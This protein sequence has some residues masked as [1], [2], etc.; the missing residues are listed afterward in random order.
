MADTEDITPV[1]DPKRA[2]SKSPADPAAPAAGGLGSATYE[3]I[4]Q[5]LQAQGQALRECMS[6]LDA[7]RQEVFGSI[8]YELLQADRI[9]TA[10][11]CIPRD[12]VQLGDGRFLFGFNIQFGLKQQV[13]LAD[14]FAVYSRENE[15]GGFKEAGLEVLQDDRFLADFKR[16]YNVYEKTAFRKLSVIEGQLYMV[17]ATGSGVNDIA[18]FKWAFD[19]GALRYIDGRAEAEYRRVGFPAP[20]EFRWRL[21]DRESYRYGDHPHISIEDRVFVECT[22]GDLTIKVEDNTATGQGIYAEPVDDQYQKVDDADV[23]YAIL[24]HLILLKIRPYKEARARFFIYN[25]KLESVSRVDSL[26]QSCVLLPED[27]GL[28]FPDGYYLAT[29]ELKRFESKE[30]DMLIERVVRAPNGEDVLYVFYNRLT[31]DYVLMPYRLIGQKVEE[32]FSCNGFTLFPNGHFALFRAEQ[33]P[34]KHHMIQLW[35]TPFHQPG[36]EPAG[37]REA[38]LYQVG[39]KA[40]VRC[41]SEC[42]EVLTLLRKESPYAELYTDLVKRCGTILDAYSW[43]AGDEGFGMDA[44]LRQVREAADKAVDEF[45]KVR[46]LRQEAVRRVSASRERCEE[47]FQEVRRASFSRLNDYVGNL[48]ALRQL[49]GELITLKEVRYVEVA[50]VDEIEKQVAAETAAL[51]TACVRFLLKPEALEPY[52]K[53]ATEQLERVE[54]IAKV[55]EGRDI[56]KAVARAGS[57]L[58]MLIEIVNGLKIEDA[59]ETTRIIDGITAVYST[60]NQVKGAL[61]KQLKKLTASEKAAQFA[62]QL[63]L[64]GQSAASYLDLC[65]TPAKCEDYL[66]RISVQ[67]EELEGT[68]ADFEDYVVQLSE[69]RTELYEAFEQRKVA[70]IEQRN[71]RAGALMTAAERILKVIQN[72]LAGFK[73]LEE[74]NTYM[75]SDLMI[76]KVRETIDQLMALEDSVKADDLQGR[77]KSAQQEA[78]RQ[79]KDRQELF[80]EGQA[81]IKLGQ[82]RFNINTQPLDLTVVNRDRAQFIHLTSTK[83][84]DRITDE[85]FL[86]TRDVWDQEVVSENAEVYRGEYLAHR[87]LQ[88][89]EHPTG[90]NGDSGLGSPAPTP[91][92]ALA[93]TDAE[94]LAVVRQFISGRY[95]EGY[96]KGIHDHDGAQIFKALLSAHLSLQLA[97][98]E[99]VARACALVFWH[100]FCPADTVALWT[101]KLSGF[102][103]RNRLFPGDPGQADYTAALES[104]L[105]TFTRDTGLYSGTVV[106]AAGEYLF[107][108]LIGGDTVAISRDAQELL[109]AFETHL[110]TQGSEGLFADARKALA[111]HPASE[112]ELVRD[113]VRGF[114]LGR[115]DQEPYAEE[116]VALLFCGEDLNRS[117]VEAGTRQELDAMKGSHARIEGSRYRF[118]Y[119]GFRRRLRGFELEVVPRFLQSH[120]LKQALLDR[121]R[122]ALRLDEFRPRVL[123]SFVRNQLLD[124][125]YLPLI[126][127]NLAK[128]VG[129]AGDQRRTDLM[130]LLLLISPPGYGKTTLMEY[131]ASRLGIVFIKINGPALGHSVSSLDPEEAPN[132]AAREEVR[133][134]NLALEMGDNA[135][136]Y[137]DDIQHCNP[138]FL[139]KFISLCDAQRK[140][141]GVWRGQ[142]RTYDL[143]GRKVVVVM[144]GNPYTESGQK[145]KIPDML[146]N[147]ADTYNLGDIIGGSAD[148]FKMSYLENA[149]TSNPVLAP[150][151]N[152]SQKDI[153]AFIHMA[154]SG[155]G[156]GDGFEGS[157]AS[158]EIEEILA[159]MRKLVAVREIIL[160]V[161]LEYIRSAAQA[162]EYRTEPAFKLQ[163]SYRN[164]NRLAEKVVPIMNDA[165]VQ[166]LVVDHYKGESQTLT[167]GAEANFLKFKELIGVQTA[168]ETA[169]WEAIKKTFKRNL[170]AHGGD[171]S[172]PVGRVVAQLSTFQVGLES[173]Q[174][175]LESQLSKAQ[176]PPRIELDLQPVAQGL[177]SLQAALQADSRGEDA[178]P[179]LDLKPLGQS[180]EAMRHALETRLQPPAPRADAGAEGLSLLATRIGES[181]EGLRGDLGRAISEVHTGSMAEKMGSLMH[182]ME[183]LHST[184]ATLKDI[185]AR[186]RDYVRSVEAM[187]TAR[188]KDGTVEIQL[189]QEMLENEQAFLEQFQR[190]MNKDAPEASE[191]PEPPEEA[192]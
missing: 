61:K 33:E 15:K 35:Q 172:D 40:V 28:I 154:E 67:L 167:T 89:L 60:L 92:E 5:R 46:R 26:G 77:L 118:D 163:G 42:N 179:L 72:R 120:E 81:V 166:A 17:F 13:Q 151:A 185:A 173:I 1:E 32:R 153:R 20:Y 149:V 19:D 30:R 161:N 74:I 39:N 97:R 110:V 106:G 133:K 119:L 121:E 191:K 130:G 90:A 34:Q 107:Q 4:R 78:V 192:T 25:E 146:A 3:I 117:V 136:I 144:A 80:V 123:T 96:T 103:A 6:R 71:R 160:S 56:E 186:Q 159:V 24:G 131:I 53:E 122:R 85:A 142:P 164:M 21:P 54:G 182:E 69:R 82:H 27:H 94:R 38:F 55:A 44:T 49:R 10:H 43:L 188:A 75:A 104:L 152:K 2:G 156:A 8:D 99:P 79:L 168:E 102:A 95:Q 87:L 73:T 70:L 147:R 139:Q 184:L 100:R 50:E 101:A 177:A 105:T 52:R 83:Y 86:A 37:N 98:Y 190:A 88:A 170:L 148:T 129:A 109:K 134:L 64:L 115:P 174:Q 162:D 135:M 126:G 65:D 11:N 76:A 113:W 145:F 45:D 47:R 16:L 108:E 127:D 183:M 178:R 23:G 140:I 93:M 114:L 14:V 125:V 165:E 187:L 155:N 176:E 141:E 12:M 59:T 22:E 41:L 143:R 18:V 128:Q 91:A 111:D 138:E 150:L 137:V 9:V 36:M 169:R 112:L 31:G 84:F 132:A 66:N 7:R 171:Q 116:V 181:L 51:A 29:G 157:Y 57:E 62:A 180:L 158:Q 124:E 68:F 175:T 48:A 63:K 189:T 58:E